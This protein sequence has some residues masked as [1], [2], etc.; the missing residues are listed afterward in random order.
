[1]VARNVSE[2]R[3]KGLLGVSTHLLN[4]RLGCLS[5]KREDIVVD[6]FKVGADVHGAGLDHVLRLGAANSVQLDASLGL[7]L[8]NQHLGLDRVECDTSTTG[9]SSGCSTTPMDVGLGLLGRLK[10]D[11]EV[12]VGDVEAS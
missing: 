12:D 8:L 6:L 7:D 11:D 2:C 10:L 5:E 3:A 1:V 4:Q 9:S